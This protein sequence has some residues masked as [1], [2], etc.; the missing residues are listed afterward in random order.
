MFYLIAAIT[1]IAAVVALKVFISLVKDSFGRSALWGLFT[2][3]MPILGVLASRMDA[4]WNFVC[5][6]AQLA[7]AVTY[8]AFFWDDIKVAFLV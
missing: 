4:P 8:A 5:S 1:G 7:V 6:G 2:L 3:L